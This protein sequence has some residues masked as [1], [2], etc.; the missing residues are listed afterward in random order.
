[1]DAVNFKWLRKRKEVKVMK[2]ERENFY[3]NV[4]MEYTIRKYWDGIFNYFDFNI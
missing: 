1:M 4:N 3:P 2:L